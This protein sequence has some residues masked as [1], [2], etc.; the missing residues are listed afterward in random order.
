MSIPRRD[1]SVTIADVQK[2]ADKFLAAGQEY[3][4]TC[5][6]AGLDLGSV[7]YIQDSAKGM[8]IFTRGEYSDTLM[9]NIPEVGRVYNLGGVLQEP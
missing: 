2:A 4:D 7:T 5:R 8:A 9:R 3:W 6:K 1:P